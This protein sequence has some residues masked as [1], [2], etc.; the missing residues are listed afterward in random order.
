MQCSNHP[1]NPAAGMCTYSGKP[2]C[3]DCLVEVEGKMYAKENL[4]KV[5]AEAKA[6]NSN[7]P[8]VFMNSSSS[9]SSAAAVGGG[10][11]HQQRATRSKGTAM[12]L[13]LLLVIGLGG[14]HRFYTGHTGIGLV[15]L[16]TFGGFL[17]WGIIDILA[18]SGGTYRDVDGMHLY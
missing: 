6:S 14:L 12:V 1:G 16:F 15:Q 9:S 2:Y 3:G 18:I 10:Y 7:Q 5:M 13:S 11:G 8:M 17:I 4:G